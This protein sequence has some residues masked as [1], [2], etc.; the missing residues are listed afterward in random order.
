MHTGDPSL[1]N[2][3]AHRQRSRGQ[4]HRWGRLGA[5]RIVPDCIRSLQHGETVPVLESP[6]RRVHGSM[7]SEPLSG[8]LW[9]GAALMRPEL[10]QVALPEVA[11]AFNFGPEKE[12][13][14]PV[15][16]LVRE[17]AQE[18]AGK[19]GGQERPARLSR[20][21]IAN[22]LHGQGQARAKVEFRVAL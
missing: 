6:L 1:A 8:Y 19:M 17:R 2:S 12:A 4:C 5:D 3:R 20:S 11:T 7:S 13:N 22:A 16:D 14:R 10:A 9:L 15:A 18:L 21:Q